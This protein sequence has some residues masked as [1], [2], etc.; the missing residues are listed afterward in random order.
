ME[1]NEQE[2]QAI[3]NSKSSPP[4]K[5]ENIGIDDLTEQTTSA[6]DVTLK[7][8]SFETKPK[9]EKLSADTRKLINDERKMKRDTEE[10]IDIEREL[11]KDIRKDRR[12]YHTKIK[13]NA[14]DINM[15]AQQQ[16]C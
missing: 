13:Q 8:I 1:K 11:K 9:K 2:L 15:T 16:Q 7:K 6:V 4:E 3:I 14:M 10:L 12:Q 5:F